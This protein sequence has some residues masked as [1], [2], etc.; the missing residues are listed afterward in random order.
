MEER[1]MKLRGEN[2]GQ[3]AAWGLRSAYPAEQ[4]HPWL[5]SAERREW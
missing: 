2:P 4:G 5:S 1:R 3:S